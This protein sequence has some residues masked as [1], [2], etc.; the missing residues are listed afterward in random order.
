MNHLYELPVFSCSEKDIIEGNIHLPRELG[1]ISLE[2]YDLE[3]AVNNPERGSVFRK[4]FASKVN[5]LM[6][7]GALDFF[8]SHE[9]GRE[10][11]RMT[12][13]KDAIFVRERSRLGPMGSLLSLML[14]FC[15]Q[16]AVLFG[17]QETRTILAVVSCYHQFWLED[18]AMSEGIQSTLRHPC[19]SLDAPA[20]ESKL[21][22]VRERTCNG[23]IKSFPRLN[24]G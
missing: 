13:Q 15:Q 14:S 6:Q 1:M 22:A 17:R 23:L 21:H 8:A 10:S 20:P 7:E 16:S 5:E 3:K 19:K 18:T 11:A 4:N 2:N 24:N 9:V 12:M